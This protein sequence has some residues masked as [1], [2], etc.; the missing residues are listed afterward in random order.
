VRRFRNNALRSDPPWDGVLY[1]PHPAP[2]E[3]P[4]LLDTFDAGHSYR[5]H[6][7]VF[8]SLHPVRQSFRVLW[9]FARLAPFPDLNL[10][11]A[12]LAMCGHL[13]GK[14]YP[15]LVP[16]PSDRELVLRLVS[17]PPPLRMTRWEARLLATVS[18]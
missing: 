2:G 14:G 11:M 5:D 15:L 12:W 18:A 16:E 7:A 9:R 1:V 10:P 8:A 13:L 3:L 4:A 6:P 17:G